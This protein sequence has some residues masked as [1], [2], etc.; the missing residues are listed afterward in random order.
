MKRYFDTTIFANPLYEYIK[1]LFI[2]IYYQTTYWGKHL[3]ISYKAYVKRV[4][5]GKYN[6]IGKNVFLV[7]CSIGD[8]TYISDSSTITNT[9]IGKFC[10]IGPNTKFAPGKHPTSKIVSTHPSIFSNPG[11]M[12]K[13]FTLHSIYEGNIKVNI[14]NDVWVGADCVIIDGIT[15]A[16]GVIIA[17]NSVVTKDVEPYCIVGGIPAKFIRKRFEDDEIQKLLALKWWDKDEEWIQ[18]NISAFWDIKEF[19]KL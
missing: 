12:G 1:W 8:F 13:N 11:F 18:Q 7:D 10:S 19:V 3:R 4:R 5:F 2:K 16:D 17:A 14:G 15:I 6:Y 9:N